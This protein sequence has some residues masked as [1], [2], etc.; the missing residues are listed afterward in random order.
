[1][2]WYSYLLYARR[3]YSAV[4]MARKELTRI[5]LQF[6]ADRD[7]AHCVRAISSLLRRLCISVFP[8]NET[9]G[10]TGAEWL[11]FL[12]GGAMA[13]DKRQKPEEREGENAD[14]KLRDPG[15]VLL[16]APYRR[17]VTG[18]EVEALIGFCSD[19]IE[20][21]ARISHRGLRPLFKTGRDTP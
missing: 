7:A 2:V 5:R 12:Q 16:E 20:A 11:T 14:E 8:R 10:L 21:I 18:A 19:R 9:A 17:Q 4:N 6:A 13:A 3:K 15:R 1:M